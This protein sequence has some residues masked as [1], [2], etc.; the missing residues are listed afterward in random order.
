MEDLDFNIT[1]VG[2]GL[3]GGSFVMALRGLK[4]KKLWGIDL[5]TK[6]IETAEAMGIID[7]GYTNAEIPLKDSDIVILA[8]YPNLTES[9]IRENNKYFKSGAIITDTAG[10]KGELVKSINAF[11]RE[12]VDFIGGHPMAGKEK[13]GFAFATKDIFEN[14]NYIFTPTERNKEENIIL[15]EDIMRKIGCKNVVRTTPKEH[16]EIIAYT[17]HLPHILAVALV[18]S[19][20]KGA[21]TSLF[22]AGGFKD[23]TRIADANPCL[24]AE[25]LNSNNENIIK[26]IDSFEEK[27]KVIKNA[28]IEKNSDIIKSE[29]ERAGRRRKE[30]A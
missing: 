1:V 4:P 11:I 30:L 28:I 6:V 13:N 21:E 14:A 7:K 23:V 26:S 9:F 20:L 19:D 22:I 24:W 8:L 3:I 29:F 12:D 2:L 17:S 5:D 18:N 10:I 25:L 27:I 15:L 16:D